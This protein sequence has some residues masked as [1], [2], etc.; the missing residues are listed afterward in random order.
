MREPLF[1][2]AHYINQIK[3]SPKVVIST[4]VNS[5]K[6]VSSRMLKQKKRLSLK[7]LWSNNLWSPSYF[8]NS[9]RSA[10]IDIIRQY[11]QQQ[12]TPDV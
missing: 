1:P 7:K 12:N 11:I 8:S 9:C 3:Y 5:L 6:G 4:F 2:L 10:P